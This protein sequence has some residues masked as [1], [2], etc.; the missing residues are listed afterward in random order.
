MVTLNFKERGTTEH[1]QMGKRSTVS[2]CLDA[3][4]TVSHSNHPTAVCVHVC[5]CV[6]VHMGAYAGVCACARLKVFP[7]E[8]STVSCDIN[9]SNYTGHIAL[10]P[11]SLCQLPEAKLSLKELYMLQ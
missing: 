3:R 4:V 1:V 6:C 7:T 2:T 11:A 10:P 9:E 8:K 5:I